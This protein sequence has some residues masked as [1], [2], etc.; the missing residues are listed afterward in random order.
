MV[1]NR[2]IAIRLGNTLDV[3]AICAFGETHIR[4]HY[5]PLIGSVAACKQV[6][7]WWS[8]NVI[9]RAVGER[10]II[11]AESGDRLVGVTQVS[12]QSDPP[13][14][15]KLYV[16]PSWRGRGVASAMIRYAMEKHRDTRANRFFLTAQSD[17]LELYRPFGFLAFG[18]EFFDAGMPHRA[19]RNY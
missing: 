18:E 7:D 4:P 12:V 14:I 8:H 15:Y 1:H 16:H 3:A 9:V 5:E 11:I 6:S 2:D 19:M 17:K 13:T 10:A